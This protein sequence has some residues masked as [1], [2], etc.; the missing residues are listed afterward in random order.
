[1]PTDKTNNQGPRSLV[2][3]QG[4]IGLH[5]VGDIAMLQS[6]TRRLQERLPGYQVFVVESNEDR[7]ARFCPGTRAL[8]PQW[9]PAALA[10]T[11]FLGARSRKT[12]P[13]A[14][15]RALMKLQEHVFNG[16]PALRLRAEQS[17]AWIT[18]R[19]DN[20]VGRAVE[21]WSGVA[22]MVASGMGMITDAFASQAFTMLEELAFASRAGVPIALFGQGIGPIDR[23]DLYDLAASTF[24]GAE[25]IALRE[26]LFGR[27][28]LEK[29]GARS[30]ARVT[31]DDA[32]EFVVGRESPALG[33]MIGV[34]I[35]I[36]SYAATDDSAAGRVKRGLAQ[37]AQEL[38]S[39]V[40]GIPISRWEGESDFESLPLI[41]GDSGVIPAVSD[42]DTPDKVIGLVGRCRVVVTGSYHAGVFALGQ[43]IPVVGLSQS[44]YYVQK[45][46]GLAGMFP[47]GVSCVRTDRE[48]AA[49]AIAAA[50]RQAWHGAPAVR[51]GLLA[52]AADQ[53]RRGRR[54]YDDYCERVRSGCAV[55]VS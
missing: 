27:P 36:S 5:N 32:L 20:G 6:C 54:A 33:S 9:R 35:R 46:E 51:S 1:M 42:A 37:A 18:G 3:W 16:D 55:P 28:L 2:V 47:G 19:P 41:V 21:A 38:Q 22:G 15:D 53:L 11:S 12:M 34:N 44:Q 50:V 26:E 10:K 14:L 25:M 24:A 39:S 29:M 4:G 49:E 52:S 30:N 43:G 13:P 40:L 7:L 31:G 48:D 23:Q 17:K 8:D 45:F